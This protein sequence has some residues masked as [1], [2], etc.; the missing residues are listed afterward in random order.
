MEM[1]VEVEYLGLYLQGG[2]VPQ[3]AA[4]GAGGLDM[5]G[6]TAGEALAG[7]VE[8]PGEVRSAVFATF[9]LVTQLILQLV[10]CGL[11]ELV[12]CGVGEGLAVAV[13]DLE[14]VVL[15]RAEAGALG[16]GDVQAQVGAP[17]GDWVGPGRDIVPDLVSKGIGTGIHRR[18]GDRASERGGDLQEQGRAVGVHDPIK[19]LVLMCEQSS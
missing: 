10:G 3:A 9:E 16:E 12:G 19:D 15:F 13:L 2:L 1:E 18:L 14:V 11:E 4:V 7:L 5:A 8:D 17:S 6:V